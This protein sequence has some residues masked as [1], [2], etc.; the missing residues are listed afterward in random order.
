MKNPFGCDTMTQKQAPKLERVS[1]SSLIST[2]NEKFVKGPTDC[3]YYCGELFSGPKEKRNFYKHLK[4]HLKK[5]LSR[6]RNMYHRTQKIHCLF[7]QIH[8]G[9]Q[10]RK[11]KKNCDII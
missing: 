3:D 7:C 4:M 10:I 6:K 8:R 1:K 2:T 9:L 5:I 11:S